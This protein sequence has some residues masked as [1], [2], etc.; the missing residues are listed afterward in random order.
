MFD[1]KIERLAK[2][3]RESG[4][5][6]NP[7]I[8]L[9]AL[10]KAEEIEL[11]SLDNHFEFNGKKISSGTSARLSSIIQIS[12]PTSG[13]GDCDSAWGMNSDIITSRS[14]VRPCFKARH[15]IQTPVHEAQGASGSTNLPRLF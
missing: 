2:E 7:P 5:A 9:L 15:T 1:P 13:R 8:D 3:A 6:K 11:I 12:R 4:D 14:T 10:C